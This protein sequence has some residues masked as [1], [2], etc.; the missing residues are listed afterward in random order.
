MASDAL[1]VRGEFRCTPGTAAAPMDDRRTQHSSDTPLG[2]AR[3]LVVPRVEHGNHGNG[4]QPVD[5]GP[6][7]LDQGLLHAVPILHVASRHFLRDGSGK[8]VTVDQF[9]ELRE[10]PE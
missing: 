9:E 4:A 7:A 1:A 6:L 5:P 10:L 8:R 3:I 2:Y